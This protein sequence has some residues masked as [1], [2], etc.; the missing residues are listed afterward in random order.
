MDIVIDNEI[1]EKYEHLKNACD[2]VKIGMFGK[3]FPPDLESDAYLLEFIIYFINPTYND[4][5]CLCDTY[6]VELSQI[7]KDL[8]YPVVI[9]FILFL[10][11]RFSK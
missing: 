2:A 8:I 5:D 9:Q 10:K 3:L 4:L 1:T 11:K 6:G 7:E